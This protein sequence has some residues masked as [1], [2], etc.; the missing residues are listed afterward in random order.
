[1]FGRFNHQ[2]AFGQGSHNAITAWEVM[3]HGP[4][5]QRKLAQQE[6]VSADLMSQITVCRRVDQ[7]QPRSHHGYRACGRRAGF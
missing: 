4:G 3:G 2:Y 5:A 1:M 6:T 7:V